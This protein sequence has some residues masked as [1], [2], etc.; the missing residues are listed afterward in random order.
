MEHQSFHKIG[1]IA[2]WLPTWPNR[3]SVFLREFTICMS[4]RA[5]NHVSCTTKHGLVAMFFKASLRSSFVCLLFVLLETCLK[6]F[7]QL[8]NWACYE[9]N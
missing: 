3:V 6:H 8:G 9:E 4:Q 1:H 7:A 5:E 2:R